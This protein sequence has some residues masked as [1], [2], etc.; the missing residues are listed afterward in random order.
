M[1]GAGGLSSL[2]VDDFCAEQTIGGERSSWTSELVLWPPGWR[3]VFSLAD[4]REVT[5]Q[6]GSKELFLI[7]LAGELLIAA[8]VVRRWP[9]VTQPL[10]LVAVT[11]LALAV[12]GAGG[13]VGGFVL[14]MLAAGSLALPAHWITSPLASSAAG[15]HRVTVRARTTGRRWSRTVAAKVE[16]G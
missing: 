9:R 8:L 16:L 7:V 14:A 12:A 11:M 13:L 2:E 10:L 5:V 4:G 6:A 3:C 15:R 1:L